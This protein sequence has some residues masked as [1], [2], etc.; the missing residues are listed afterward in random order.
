MKLIFGTTNERK[1]EDLIKMAI[2]DIVYIDE[3]NF[4]Q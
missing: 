2:Y 4:I 1:V 3:G